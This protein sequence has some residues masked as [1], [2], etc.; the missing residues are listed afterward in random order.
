MSMRIKDGISPELARMAR[1]FADRKPILQAM[2]AGLVGVAQDAF[3]D[4]GL[5]PAPWEPSRNTDGTFRQTLLASGA[6]RRSV[7]I[8]SLTGKAVTVGVDRIYGA[9][10]QFGGKIT[11]KGGALHFTLGGKDIFV[12]SVQIPAR[13]YFPFDDQ[14]NMTAP[15]QRRV[16]AAARAKMR[17]M[18]PPGTR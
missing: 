6:L 16:E 17:A 13:P 5:R 2:G 10:H 3:R 1:Q 18:M 7:R 8:V 14:G 12:K 4:S 15:G 9:I 11:A